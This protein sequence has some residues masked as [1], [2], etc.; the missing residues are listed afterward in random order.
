SKNHSQA[1][2][3]LAHPK[4]LTMDNP[5]AVQYIDELETLRIAGR[6]FL[7][8]LSQEEVLSITSEHALQISQA[9]Y[10]EI[11]IRH[12]NGKDFISTV[13]HPK[14]G[15]V[16]AA[17]KEKSHTLVI[18]AIQKQQSIILDQPEV[19][20]PLLKSWLIFPFNVLGNIVGALCLGHHTANA[21]SSPTVKLLSVFVDQASIA[22]SNAQLFEDLTEAY[23]KLSQSRAQILESSNTLQALF[24]GISDGLYIIDHQLNIITVNRAEITR[25]KQPREAILTQTFAGLGWQDAAPEFIDLIRQTFSTGH[26]AHWIPPATGNNPL[27]KNREMHLYP[28]VTPSEA[29]QQV[30]VLAQDMAEQR[31]LQASLFQSAN[32]AAIGQL[33]TSVA[34]EINNPLTIALTNT[35]LLM[36]ELDKS[37]PGYELVEDIF[38]SNTR[39]KTIVANLVDLSNQDIY[40]FERLNLIETIE[41][42]LSLIAHPV[43]QAKVTIEREYLCAPA[44]VGS[45]SHLKLA[46]MNLFLNAR[47]AIVAANRRGTITINV[48][49]TDPAHV[50]VA[51]TDDGIG[52]RAEHLNDIFRPFF[53][54]KPFGTSTGL[55]LF[56]THA[57]IE[58]HRGRI[59]CNCVAGATSFFV[60]LPNSGPTPPKA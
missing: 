27:L 22:I 39:I 34:H 35:Q 16:S 36:M 44:I 7:N 33:A 53:T 5:N 26:K 32:L 42:A 2:L 37:H 54:T 4:Y 40:R 21:F 56:T 6:L 38:A 52:I 1:R 10:C 17:V 19:E 43:R 51:I 30:I 31:R 46:W 48:R 58:R 18:Q 28:I 20:S 8:N 49:Q 11:F 13:H 12:P 57:I 15:A 9:T 41:D 29:V 14:T 45:R 25:L 23:S 55:G 3:Y 47:D 24:E 50:T 60:T 59:E